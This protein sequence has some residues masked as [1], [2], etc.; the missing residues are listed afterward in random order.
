[1]ALEGQVNH[2]ADVKLIL[3]RSCLNDL[4]LWLLRGASLH[5]LLHDRN[6]E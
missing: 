6:L 2:A 3:V 1:M 5:D 4:L